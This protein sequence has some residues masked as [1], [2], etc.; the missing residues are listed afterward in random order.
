M[1]SLTAYCCIYNVTNDPLLYI[2][3]ERDGPLNC[4]VWDPTQ[5]EGMKPYSSPHSQWMTLFNSQS[6]CC[7]PR[8]CTRDLGFISLHLGSALSAS[9]S[10]ARLQT[11]AEYP[12]EQTY[13]LLIY[14]N[15]HTQ[16]QTEWTFSSICCW[17]DIN[18]LHWGSQSVC[19]DTCFL[20]VRWINCISHSRKHIH[21]P[22]CFS[23]FTMAHF[24]FP[25]SQVHKSWWG[26]TGKLFPQSVW[27][28]ISQTSIKT[29]L[30]LRIII[31]CID[32]PLCS[33]HNISYTASR[34]RPEPY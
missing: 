29:K 14:T 8:L 26:W 30:P 31:L 5:P 23:S 13:V 16:T 21:T 10:G 6:L 34:V 32:I 18:F 3:P 15:I 28:L 2:F 17:S 20:W 4:T 12:F 24:L 11:E 27:Q 25:F 22:F 19:S 33:M 1:C 9:Y 7:F